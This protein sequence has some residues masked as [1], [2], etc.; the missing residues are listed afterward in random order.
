MGFMNAGLG[1]PL[2]TDQIVQTGLSVAATGTTTGLAIAGA[3]A[4]IP[5]VGPI[6]AGLSLLASWVFG[7]QAKYHAQE[8]AA[9]NDA[10]AIETQ[11]QANLAA[12]MACQIDQPTAEANYEKLW[13]ELQN[14]CAQIGGPAGERCITDRQAGACKWKNDGKGGPAGSG[15]VCWN[16]D[17]GYRLPLTQSAPCGGPAGASSFLGFSPL[18]LALAGGAL[19]LVGSQS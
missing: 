7:K 10:N 13:S 18:M 5:F 9:S 1:A 11:M 4:A 6:V 3:T 2:T 8:S 15:D 19:I 17:V 12:Y 14:A 16:W